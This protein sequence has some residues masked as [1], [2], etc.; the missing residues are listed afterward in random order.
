MLYPLSYGR[1][2]VNCSRPTLAI[3]V[4]ENGTD[5]WS[6]HTNMRLKHARVTDQPRPSVSRLFHAMNSLSRVWIVA[7][8]IVG[9][10]PGA[11]ST[12]PQPQDATSAILRAFARYDVVG[13]S[14][15]HG[16]K[17]LNAFILSLIRNPALPTTINDIVVEC[18]NSRYQAVLDRYIAGDDVSIEEAR[19][20]WRNTS[21]AMC[22]L[23]GF[24][25]KFFPL[26]RRINQA[27]PP[28]NRLRVL[29]ADPPFDWSV[30]D[31]AA[32]QRGANRDASIA[33]VI[34]TEV[35]S[36]KRK[37]LTLVGVGH[38]YHHELSRGTAVSE[39]EKTYPG[40]TLIIETHNG[41]AAFVDLARGHQLEARMQSWPVPSIVSI[42]GT[43]LADLDL[44]YYMWPFPKRMAGQSIADLADAYL[45]L[46]PADSLTFEKIPDS[47]LADK[48]YMAELTRR[49]G[50]DVEALR[51]RNTIDRLYTAADRQEALSFALGARFVGSYS[52]K[53]DE[54]SV[55]EIDYRGGE[56]AARLPGA[57][58]WLPLRQ[59]DTPTRY[60]AE[61]TAG[62]LSL[63]FESVEGEVRGL[64]LESGANQP[65]VSFVRIR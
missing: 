6:A 23:S 45:Y 18:G 21:V 19:Q 37:A 34:V 58:S 31:P 8:A 61:V 9:T 7:I 16:H 10:F 24:Y 59:T 43:W 29:G 33:S 5:A 49:F 63:G 2:S 3:G 57:E 53:T 15:G 4:R 26:I 62:A 20:V 54:K 1:T 39:Y 22:G 11:Q 14:A 40:R 13:M 64:T 60:I 47:I 32:I 51:R 52:N 25:S 36:K 28:R 30:G 55:V 65:K 44:P 41:F 42:K 56:L 17:E 38:L 50:L 35:L 27:L 12:S 48:G 46:G